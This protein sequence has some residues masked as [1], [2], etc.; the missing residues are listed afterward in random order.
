MEIWNKNRALFL[1]RDGVINERIPGEYIEFPAQFKFTENCLEA[2]AVFKK[3]FNRIVVVTNQ[4]GIG[5]GIMTERQLDEIHAFMK[6][7]IEKAGG[8]IDQIYHCPELAKDNPDC[9]KPNTGMAFQAQK[10]F[11][12]I[13]FSKSVMVG[14]SIS[15]MEFGKRLEMTTILIDG[16]KEERVNDYIIDYKFSSLFDFAMSI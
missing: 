15:D 14:D 6:A 8:K 3:A 16:K 11:P 5:K 13:D 9:R 2:M 1:D 12:E 10:D 7:A 4:Q